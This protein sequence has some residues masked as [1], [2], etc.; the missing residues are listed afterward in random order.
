MTEQNELLQAIGDLAGRLEAL[1]TRTGAALDQLAAETERVRHSADLMEQ[2]NFVLHGLEPRLNALER[3]LVDIDKMAENVWDRTA[4]SRR[5]AMI[6]DRLVT[7]EP[8]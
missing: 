6:E 5:L 3:S 8:Q 4:I 2:A 7:N 1:E